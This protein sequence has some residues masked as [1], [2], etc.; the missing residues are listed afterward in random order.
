MV[1]CCAQVLFDIV[2]VVTAVIL[3]FIGTCLLEGAMGLNHCV[4]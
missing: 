4:R 3:A 2:V 1:S